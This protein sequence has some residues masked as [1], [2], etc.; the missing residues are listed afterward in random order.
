MISTNRK[1][2]FTVAI[3]LAATA[4]LFFDKLAGG[5]YV[6]LITLLSGIYT[7]GN[8][9]QKQVRGRVDG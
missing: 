7:G 9:A 6:T 4:A 5:E 1:F 3:F 2:K 8:V